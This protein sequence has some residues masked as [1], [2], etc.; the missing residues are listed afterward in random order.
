MARALHHGV[1][2]G[3]RGE[4]S[5]GEGD[6]RA[7]RDRADRSGAIASTAPADADAGAPAVEHHVASHD[8][9]FAGSSELRCDACNRPLEALERSAEADDDGYAIPGEGVYLWARGD[10]VRYEKTALCPP[11]A[12]AIGMTA[13]ARWEIEEEEG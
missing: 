8:I 5:S 4:S 13:L 2:P 7:R 10:E 3:D 12:A 11:C 1:A 9:L 6:A